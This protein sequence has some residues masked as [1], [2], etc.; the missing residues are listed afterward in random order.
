M[1]IANK[2]EFCLFPLLILSVLIWIKPIGIKNVLKSIGCFLLV[3]FISFASLFIQGLTFADLKNAIDIWMNLI[4]SPII[5][6][7][8]ANY[9]VTIDISKYMEVVKANDFFSIYG[10]LPIVNFILFLNCKYKMIFFIF[11]AISKDLGKS[12]QSFSK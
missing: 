12:K 2:Y 4:T 9:G 1:S 11:Y 5:K 7:F 8:F 6:T 10:F 3:P